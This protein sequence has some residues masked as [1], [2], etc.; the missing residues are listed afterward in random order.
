MSDPILVEVLRGETAESRHAGA[1]AVSD[2]EGR[3][4][5]SAGDV[6][7]PIHP[8]SAV[9]ALQALPLI[10]SGAAEKY[11]LTDRQIALAVASH[12]GEP[13]HLATAAAMLAKAGRSEEA[14]E[15]GAHW[16]YDRQAANDLVRQGKKPGPLHNN[17]SGKHAGFI[18]TAC[19]EGLDPTGYSGADH[20][21]MR[22]VMGVMADMAG[23]AMD[24]PLVGIDG[25]S[26]PTQATPLAHLARAFARFGSGEYLGPERRKA[27][28]RIRKAVAAEPFMIAGTDEFCTDITALFGARVFVKLGAEGVFCAAFPDLGLGAALKCRDGAKRAAEVMM[29]ALIERFM[30]MSEDERR[31]LDRFVRPTLK[32]WNGLAVGAIRPVGLL[33]SSD[34]TSSP[35]PRSAAPGRAGG[36]HRRTP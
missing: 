3:L 30:P 18:C 12:T 23:S 2:G 13:L 27:A 5:L 11:A 29:A 20:P 15:C 32:N 21:V 10:E 17:C 19:V 35:T 1:F 22:A 31:K 7:R 36:G 24:G 6:H 34:G 14:L 4:V 33:A 25:C 9:K 8:R 16:P 28:A 26:I